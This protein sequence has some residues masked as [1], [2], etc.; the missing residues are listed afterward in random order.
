M[1]AQPVYFHHIQYW[2]PPYIHTIIPSLPSSIDVFQ[3]HLFT[4]KKKQKKN[5]RVY[6]HTFTK[7][8]CIQ[9]SK[10]HIVFQARPKKNKK[11]KAIF[12]NFLFLLDS[13]RVFLKLFI[14]PLDR[15]GFRGLTSGGQAE[16]VKKKKREGKLQDDWGYVPHGN[17]AK[18]RNGDE[19]KKK[20]K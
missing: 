2:L 3:T 9:L 4:L 15:R 17:C 10:F 19:E 14:D 16:K 20:K 8:I 12:I 5:Q 7:T 11:P 13:A 18:K 1:R 6:T